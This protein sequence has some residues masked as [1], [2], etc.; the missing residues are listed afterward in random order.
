M[1]WFEREEGKLGDVAFTQIA[2]SENELRRLISIE[3]PKADLIKAS[4]E[5]RKMVSTEFMDQEPMNPD[6]ADNYNEDEFEE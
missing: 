3:D 5:F 1:G 6:S 2:D 4:G